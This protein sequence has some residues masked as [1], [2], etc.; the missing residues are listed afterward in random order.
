MKKIFKNKKILIS[1]ILV[2]IIGI[3]VGA[4]ILWFKPK[5][6]SNSPKEEEKATVVRS[7]VKP[8]TGS[9]IP[10]IKDYF[11][12]L[13]GKE[14]DY[15]ITYLNDNEEVEKRDELLTF[16]YYVD[17][18]DNEVTYDDAF[19]SNEDNHEEKVLKDG[20]KEITILKGTYN[21]TVTITNKNNE[22]EVYT[23][24]L[25]LQDTTAPVLKVKDVTITEGSEVT[26][27]SF[28]LKCD[29]NSR[30]DCNE[31][32]FAKEV[33]GEDGKV[34]YEKT[35][36]LDKSVGGHEV[37]L[38]A[39]DASGN[40][41]NVVKAKLT[42]NKKPTT[43]NKKPTTNTNPSSSETTETKPNDQESTV[44]TNS[45]TANTC[46]SKG[47]NYDPSMAYIFWGCNS[48]EPA[49]GMN[50]EINNEFYR[51]AGAREL[52]D[53]NAHFGDT[54]CVDSINVMPIIDNATGKIVGY[55]VKFVM[56]YDESIPG[57]TWGNSRKVGEGYI[58]PGRVVMTSKSY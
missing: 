52:D 43:T 47:Y 25:E 38:Q 16:T 53:C 9:P 17:K 58:L 41:S 46:G 30:E 24:R 23:S 4:T 42:V 39:S 55:Y 31:P 20:Y 36:E 33:K 22:K 14:E 28:F 49:G 15:E 44:E 2:I 5:P 10:E 50:S 19:I 45:G 29:D 32:Y 40:V 27:T 54:N 6:K 13:S 35:N 34:T 18:D 48:H 57:D 56:S 37:L 26:A 3:G 8:E 7:L 11:E 21:Y 12:Y 1:I 51:G